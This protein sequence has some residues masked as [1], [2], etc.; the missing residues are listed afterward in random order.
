LFTVLEEIRVKKSY[1]RL[2]STHQTPRPQRLGDCAALTLAAV[3]AHSPALHYAPYGEL[4]G[5]PSVVVD[6][7][8]TEGT[9]LCLSHWPG[10]GSPPE[11][12]ADL[13]A[14]MAFGYLTA[15]DRHGEA[16]VVSNNH[17]DQ[18]G[19]VGVFA[20]ASP[21]EALARRALL[22]EVAR[23]GDFAVTGSRVAARISM[24]LSAY[25][26][27]ERSPLP[28]LPTDD[29]ARTAALYRDLLGRLPEICERPD[30]WR[31]L[32]AEEHEILTGSEA[33]LASGSVEI[34]EV[35]D[36]D[37][38]VVTVP[39]QAPRGGGHRFGGQWVQG[40][41]PMAVHNAT[42][43]GA[44]LTIRGRHYEFGYRYES[45]VQFRTRA[46]RPRVDL[47]P[48]AETLTVAEATRGATVQW[49]AERISALTPRLAPTSGQESRLDPAVVR[50]LIET[51]L[52]TT[53]PAWDP[54]AITR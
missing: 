31:A 28:D 32:W 35:P 53:P 25:A 20:L 21:E 14:E 12:A 29:D 15:F 34:T 19:L 33:A 9:L 11:F 4:R 22:V 5:T 27:P 2:A 52:R 47:V 10:I 54:Y 45:W 50:T 3:D 46:V 7:S 17:F 16:T 41:H 18:D 13:S 24:V 36:V 37:L 6:G 43:R 42:D 23:A 8:P 40:L 26:D 30:R 39:E 44:L 49:E 38:A 1:G 48:L 51:H